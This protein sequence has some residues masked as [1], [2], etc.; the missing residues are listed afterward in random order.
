MAGMNLQCCWYRRRCHWRSWES[1]SNS[2][3]GTLR[4]QEFLLPC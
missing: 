2:K 1:S 4:R 3:S